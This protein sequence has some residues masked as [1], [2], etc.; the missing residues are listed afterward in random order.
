MF[1]PCFVVGFLVSFL[2]GNR[3]AEEG[4]AGRLRLLSVLRWWFCCC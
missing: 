3:L 4:K 1:G 2:F